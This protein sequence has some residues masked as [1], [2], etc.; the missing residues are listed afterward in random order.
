[1]SVYG[2]VAIGAAVGTM[3]SNPL[4]AL[5]LGAAAH[6][7]A[8][9][10]SH[11][12]LGR[13]VELFMAAAALILYTWLGGFALAT[14]LGAVGGALPDVEN[15]IRPR[16]RGAVKMYFPTHTGLLRHGGARGRWDVGWQLGIAAVMAG[17]VVWARALY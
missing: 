12:D 3:A 7:P 16:R 11:R 8:D 4:A 2:H 9:L 1:M 6:I 5:A 10:V 15:L 14:A 17:W 13:G